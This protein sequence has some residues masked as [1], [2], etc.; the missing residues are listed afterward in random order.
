MNNER[1]GRL[2]FSYETWQ[3]TVGLVM[4]IRRLKIWDGH[5]NEE[6][7]QTSQM[8]LARISRAYQD[9]EL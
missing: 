8:N 2:Y 6:T 3:A 4:M 7:L 5:F 1:S 9:E